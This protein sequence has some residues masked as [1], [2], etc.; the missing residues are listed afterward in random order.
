MKLEWLGEHRASIEAIFLWANR[1]AAHHSKPFRITGEVSLSASE[2][3]VVEYL[4]E[5]EELQL[6][7]AGV[8]RRLGVSPS[9]FTCIVARLEKRGLVQKYYHGSNR[10]DLIVLVTPEGREIYAEYARQLY[11]LWRE[12]VLNALDKLPPECEAQFAE[13]LQFL[14]SDYGQKAQPQPE[15]IPVAPEVKL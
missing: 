14:A 4:L 15:L 13:V 7:M 3:Q 2:I 11:V 9:A 12:P 1:Y 8:A 6:N 10:K 5:N